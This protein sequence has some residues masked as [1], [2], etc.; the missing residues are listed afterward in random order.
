[1]RAHV[2][3]G[4]ATKVYDRHKKFSN[5]TNLQINQYIRKYENLLI[6]PRFSRHERS[7]FSTRALESKKKA[8]VF[9]LKKRR[10]LNRKSDAFFF[11]LFW[12]T[13]KVRPNAFEYQ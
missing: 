2:N 8:S 6:I 9:E 1:M 5:R 4:K 13:R 10:Y 7:D 3:S 11:T 12:A